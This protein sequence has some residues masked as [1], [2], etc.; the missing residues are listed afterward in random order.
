M[1][2]AFGDRLKSAV[3]EG[4]PLLTVQET[5][6]VLGVSPGTV[7]KMISDGELRSV[8]LGGFPHRPIRVFAANINERITGW[9]ER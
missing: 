7:R 9:T 2:D 8:Q 5:A 4:G 6:H 1:A 3:L